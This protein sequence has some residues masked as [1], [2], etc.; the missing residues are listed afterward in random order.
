MRVVKLSKSEPVSMDGEK[1]R[2]YVRDY[3]K[4]L[5]KECRAWAKIIKK[6]TGWVAPP[7]Y[8]NVKT[9]KVR[10]KSRQ[11]LEKEIEAL[12][13]R[14]RYLER[15]GKHGN[16]EKEDRATKTKSGT[17]IETSAKRKGGR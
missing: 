2:A 13:N 16:E 3:R 14:V 1:F 17:R 11:E 15:E 10:R 4:P 5:T 8:A 9:L 12:K 6:P 7:I